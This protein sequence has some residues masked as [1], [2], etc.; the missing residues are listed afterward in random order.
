MYAY[1]PDRL[2]SKTQAIWVQV[3]HRQGNAVEQTQKAIESALGKRL[4]GSSN[5][6]LRL[7]M[8]RAHL[9]PTFL[10]IQAIGELTMGM[11][12]LG[13]ALLININIQE[14]QKE[15]GILKALGTG[16]GKI[17]RLLL[18]EIALLNALGIVLAIPLAC[19]LSV[20]MGKL[21]GGTLLHTPIPFHVDGFMMST[22]IILLLVFQWL[23]WFPFIQNKIRQSSIDL[24]RA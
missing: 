12:L 2:V 18:Q 16:P 13:L 21:L 22:S 1:A 24:V 14:R 9:Q 8:L 17:S 7:E 3:E 5:N 15:I 11:G 20:E 23:V 6:G 10:I 19:L 4:L